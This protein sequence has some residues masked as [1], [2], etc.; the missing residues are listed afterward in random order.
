MN[1][2]LINISKKHTD[3]LIQQTRRR[4]QETF[5][6]KTNKQTDT[7]SVSLLINFSDEGKWLS[8]V[9]SFEAT[10]SVFNVIHE[11]SSFSVTTQN[12]WIPKCGGDNNEKKS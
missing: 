12:H 9:T 4:P 8:A 2:E 11:N 5:K 7:F 3:T 6:F 1:D 10:K